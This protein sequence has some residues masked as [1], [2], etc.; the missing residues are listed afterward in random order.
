MAKT[1]E[2][3]FAQ[4]EKLITDFFNAS[5][6]VTKKSRKPRRRKAKKPKPAKKPKRKSP[7]KAPRR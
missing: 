7:R 6:P 3:R 4:L 2:Q 5:S 1:L